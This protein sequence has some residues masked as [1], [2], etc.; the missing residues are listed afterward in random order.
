MRTAAKRGPACSTAR[1][2]AAYGLRDGRRGARTVFGRAC[3][4]G[5]RMR[6]HN[7]WRLVES[8]SGGSPLMPTS[9]QEVT[10][11]LTSARPSATGRPLGNAGRFMVHSSS[12]TALPRRPIRA[13]AE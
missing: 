3:S 1:V 6:G 5:G 8:R 9:W 7:R 13:L 11:I 12:A 2:A 10:R 4:R